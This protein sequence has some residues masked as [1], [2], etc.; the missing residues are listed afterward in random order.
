M[1]AWDK[2][3]MKT[4]FNNYIDGTVVNWSSIARKYNITDGKGKIAPNGG[5]IAKEWLSTQGIDVEKFT[6][7]TPRG[8]GVIIRRKKLKGVGGEI[9]FPCSEPIVKTREKLKS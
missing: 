3:G 6:K 2:Q 4:E 8:D 1:V 9:S 7:K 5:Q